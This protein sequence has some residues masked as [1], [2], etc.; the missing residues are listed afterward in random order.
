MTDAVPHRATSRTATRPPLEQD[1]T[2]LV[3]G[4]LSGLVSNP[5]AGWLRVVGYLVLVGRRGLET[6]GAKEAIE[7][8]AD[9]RRRRQSPA[10]HVDRAPRRCVRTYSQDLP[11]LRAYCMPPLPSTMR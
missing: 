3:T 11:P 8:L 5:H 7:T 1:S 6:P 4:G 9:G 2:W 10:C